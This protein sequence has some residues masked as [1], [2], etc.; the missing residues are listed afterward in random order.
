VSNKSIEQLIQEKAYEIYERRGRVPGDPQLDWIQ[1]E[2][3]VTAE[4]KKKEAAKPKAPDI[5]PVVAATA[6]KA[7]VKPAAPAPKVEVKAAPTPAPKV[8]APAPVAAAPA[9]KV[10]VKK[11]PVKR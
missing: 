11:A 7:E 5:K 3:E 1:A 4:L 2:K 10:V 6:P 9:K 8:A